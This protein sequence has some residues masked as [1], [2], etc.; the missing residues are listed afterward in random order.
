MP[1]RGEVGGRWRVARGRRQSI[2]VSR[3]HDGFVNR[4]GARNSIS[5]EWSAGVTPR[6]SA[7]ASPCRVAAEQ[8]GPADRHFAAPRQPAICFYA[9]GFTLGYS[10]FAAPRHLSQWTVI[11]GNAPGVCFSQI[12][13]PAENS[14]ARRCWRRHL[15]RFNG[16][17]IP[18]IDE[19]R[20]RF[21]SAWV[22]MNT[23]GLFVRAPRVHARHSAMFENTE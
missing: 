18:D 16:F 21:I 5:R 15:L 7:Q 8:S 17:Q 11:T 14:A 23:K 10:R 12:L 22:V 3:A 9:E 1:R 20:S 4:R 19:N 13:G 2:P 6:T